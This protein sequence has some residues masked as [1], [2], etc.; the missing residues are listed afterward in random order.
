MVFRRSVVRR[1]TVDSIRDEHILS[2]QICKHKHCVEQVSRSPSERNSCVHAL[3]TKGLPND[4]NLCIYVAVS[5]CCFRLICLIHVWTFVAVLNQQVQGL[6]LGSFQEQKIHFRKGLLVPC[7]CLQV[8]HLL[9]HDELVSSGVSH[10]VSFF[11]IPIVQHK[12]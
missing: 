8:V 2:V 5:Y 3:R 12:P 7:P 9:Q 4:E 1:M 10:L 6:F 11:L